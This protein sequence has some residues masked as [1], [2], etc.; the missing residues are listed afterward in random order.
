MDIKNIVL[1]LVVIG[2]L[3]LCGWILFRDCG[4][5][6]NWAYS[7]FGFSV[8]AWT[9]A[10]IFFRLAPTAVDSLWWARL[11]YLAPISIAASF[12]Y[13]C[14]LGPHSS[15]V[16]NK[17]EKIF[18]LVPTIFMLIIV[19]WPKVL[20]REVIFVAGHEKL[21]VFGW[22]YILY[23]FYIPS[24][25]L[26]GYWLLYKKFYLQHSS[27]LVKKQFKLFLIGIVLASLGGMFTNLFLVT[28]GITD[29]NWAGP[30]FTF[31]LLIFVA[32]G[33]RRYFLFA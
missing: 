1:I 16:L 9:V 17:R 5:M 7:F 33:M 21:F 27:I 24:F 15:W 23:S 14:S 18:W 10:L 26:W 25:F 2:N 13:F 19:L 29:Y 4:K 3:F 31:F 22:G 32:Y 20:L 12:I 6:L 11:L 8:V 28:F 30:I